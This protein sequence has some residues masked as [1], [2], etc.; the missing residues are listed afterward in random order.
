MRTVA[1][2]LYAEG[3]T[4]LDFYAPLLTRLLENVIWSKGRH[5]V[6]IAD[7][8]PLPGRP[9][10]E[11]FADTVKEYAGPCNLIVVHTDGAGDPERARAERIEP[12]FSSIDDDALRKT[13]VDLVPVR[14]TEAWMLS[15][16]KALGCVLGVV[17]TRSQFGLPERTREVEGILDP[18]ASLRRI[19]ETVVGKRRARRFGIR[20]LYTRLGQETSFDELGKIPAFNRFRDS[21]ESALVR[22]SLIHGNS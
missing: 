22:V 16:A 8:L 10:R 9:S 19:H 21:F 3:M 11:C 1:V 4:D 18:K 5:E 15:D 14:E 20:P 13:L 6:R 12:W 7:V 17:R 2:G